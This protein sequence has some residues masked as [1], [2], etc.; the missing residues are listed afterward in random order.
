MSCVVKLRRGGM[1][2]SMADLFAA[3]S[4]WHVF[5]SLA[6]KQHSCSRSIPP[7]QWTVRPLD[8]SNTDEAWELEASN[9]VD[10]QPISYMWNGSSNPARTRT[11]CYIE[12]V[13]ILK[14]L[15][16]FML[17]GRAPMQFLSE[18]EEGVINKIQQKGN[19]SHFMESV[20]TAIDRKRLHDQAERVQCMYF[21]EVELLR[22]ARENSA[23]FVI[24][25]NT[26][27][28]TQD[29]DRLLGYKEEEEEESNAVIEWTDNE[30]NPYVPSV[31][32]DFDIQVTYKLLGGC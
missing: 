6:R 28:V 14:N 10:T 12:M 27:P 2:I 18:L 13:Q 7:P 24:T 11:N 1:D 20:I 15:E 32:G 16:P 29:I 25:T 23:S 31:D 9:M 4:L 8:R 26:S 21:I 5:D 22:V 30:G 19:M 3:K 17:P